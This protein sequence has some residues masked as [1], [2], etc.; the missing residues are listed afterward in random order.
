MGSS[1][2]TEHHQ[3]DARAPAKALPA[4]RLAYRVRE[5][6]Q[7]CTEECPYGRA[8]KVPGSTRFSTEDWRGSRYGKFRDTVVAP[9]DRK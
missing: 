5:T 4:Q 3:K 2:D 1:A 9:I 6:N 8:V 7:D